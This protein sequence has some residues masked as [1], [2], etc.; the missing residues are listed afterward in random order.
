MQDRQVR[1][2]DLRTNIC[3]G[4]LTV[5]GQQPCAAFDQQVLFLLYTV[6]CFA[7]IRPAMRFWGLL[8]FMQHTL[9][10]L[11]CLPAS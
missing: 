5:P 7:V 4:L 8:I 6:L 2:W 9:C 1:L 3:Q 11:H 10:A